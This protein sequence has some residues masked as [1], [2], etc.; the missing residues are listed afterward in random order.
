[1]EATESACRTLP[2]APSAGARA[3]EVVR[4]LATLAPEAVFTIRA[5][6]RVGLW[7]PAA[8][9]ITGRRRREVLDSGPEA[10]FRDAGRFASLLVDLD[11]RGSVVLEETL[12]VNAAGE[13]VPVRVFASALRRGRPGGNGS[14]RDED[15]YLVLLHDLSEVHRIRRRLIETEKLSAM[16]KIAGSVAHE[17]RN[18]LNSLFLST[19]LLE[20]ELEGEGALRETIAPTL[21]AIRE[22]VERLNQII[23]HYL[24]LSKISSTRREVLDL[25]SA[26]RDFAAEWRDRVAARGIELKVR[27]GAGRHPVG[28]DPNQVRRVLVNLVENAI[29]A[30]AGEEE[31]T[32]P[33]RERP[34]VVTLLVRPTRRAVKLVVED[35]GP[36]IPEPIRRRVFEPFFTSKARG[37]GLGLYIVRE[38]VLAHGGEIALAAGADGGTAVAIRLPKA[39]PPASAE[40]GETA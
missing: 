38:I 39:K 4:H 14:R 36:G 12:L 37:S 13:D 27:V 8:A 33:S 9:E 25:G 30:V 18:P 28:A 5:S 32:L 24:A 40:E 1:V 22:E 2:A 16:A 29:D 19:D 17:F 11:R 15:R 6:G 21:A 26:V 35:N 10:L 20:D 23:T 3:R 7:N 34:G 31:G